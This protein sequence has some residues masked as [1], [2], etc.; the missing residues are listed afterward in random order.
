MLLF[1]TY[2]IKK[3]NRLSLEVSATYIINIVHT[4]RSK[5]T[6]CLDK[7]PKIVYLF[8]DKNQLI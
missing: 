4:K 2:V 6:N 8:F 5:L 7:I 3:I 1:A